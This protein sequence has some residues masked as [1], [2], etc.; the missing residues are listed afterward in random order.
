MSSGIAAQRRT[1]APV[2]GEVLMDAYVHPA[3]LVG[4]TP[5]PPDPLEATPAS[6]D[7]GNITDRAAVAR[8]R[9][10]VRF[11]LDATCPHHPVGGEFL[12]AV[13]EVMTNAF[14]HGRPPLHLRVWTTSSRLLCTVTDRG[15]GADL[16]FS[17]YVRGDID[18]ER[19]RAGLWLA[20][21][22]CDHLD[23]YRTP[24]GFTVRLGSTIPP[25]PPGAEEAW[26]W[27]EATARDVPA[28][29]L[30]AAEL[31]RQV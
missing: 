22:T 16:L 20:R 31:L 19:T 8:A 9:D 1:G 11:L 10:Q 17:G 26:S 25:A 6:L 5:A 29:R 15:P 2:V 18:D 14:G 13:A 3:D 4:N 28:A 21:Q 7:L 30:P 24:E 12:G 27:A 23:A